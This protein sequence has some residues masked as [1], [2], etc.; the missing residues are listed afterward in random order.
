MKLVIA[1]VTVLGVALGRSD[2]GTTADAPS[3]DPC[4]LVSKADVEQIVGKLKTDPKSWRD[5]RAWF[6]GYE[7]ANGRDSLNVMLYPASGLDRIRQELKDRQE[8]NN[9]QPLNNLG[10]DAFIYHSTRYIDEMQLFARKGSVTLEVTLT[11]SPGA[12]ERVKS[13]ARKALSRL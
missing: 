10:F 11:Q 1:A 5:G 4:T 6:C 7:F 12:D 13:I 2:A 9:V 8:L 3:I